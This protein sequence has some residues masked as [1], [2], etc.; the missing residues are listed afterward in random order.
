MN[1]VPYIAVS[2]FETEEQV[3]KVGEGLDQQNWSHPQGHL[4]LVGFAVDRGTLEGRVPNSTRKVTDMQTLNDLIA[5]VPERAMATLHFDF[6]TS[7]G[8]PRGALYGILDQIEEA[9]KL[10]RLH[11]VQ[12]N[13]ARPGDLERVRDQLWNPSLGI[14]APLQRGVVEAGQ[15]SDFLK[16]AQGVVSHVLVDLSGGRGEEVTAEMLAQLLPQIAALDPEV[17]LAF[18]G[19]LSANNVGKLI[20]VARSIVPGRALSVDTESAVRSNDLLDPQAALGFYRAAYRALH[21]AN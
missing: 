15:V 3:R 4:P 2:A 16:A 7:G 20:Q 18:A 9:G 14:I 19:G 11:S 8:D 6:A 12:L 10:D 13:A 1:S 5:R 21:T 17:G